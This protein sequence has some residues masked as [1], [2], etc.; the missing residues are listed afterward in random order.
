MDSQKLLLSSVPGVKV[1]KPKG[2]FKKSLTHKETA[3]LSH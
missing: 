1:L 3:I 2:G